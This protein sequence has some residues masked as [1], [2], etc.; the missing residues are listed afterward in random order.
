MT[1]TQADIEQ[2]AKDPLK[3]TTDEGSVE[4]RPIDE[5]ITADR[6]AAVKNVPESPL[7]G[8]RVAQFKPAGAVGG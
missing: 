8:L 2:R 4:E 6:Y 5:M 3:V 1:I 7:F